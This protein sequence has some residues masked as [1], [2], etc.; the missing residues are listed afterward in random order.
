M[1][2]YCRC[3]QAIADQDGKVPI[4]AY[5]RCTGAEL[6]AKIGAL[7]M[8][9]QIGRRAVDHNASN[10]RCQRFGIENR[11]DRIAGVGMR[12]LQS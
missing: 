5:Q 11:L 4:T 7:Q 10:R 2:R 12:Q 9:R 1:G 3:R 8:R 6:A